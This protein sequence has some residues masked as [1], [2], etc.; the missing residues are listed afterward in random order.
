MASEY[1]A[2][3]RDGQDDDLYR[4]GKLCSPSPLSLAKNEPREKKS[5]SRAKTRDGGRGKTVSI[6]QLPASWLAWL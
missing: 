6:R 2:V 4:A 3:K 1:G 5:S